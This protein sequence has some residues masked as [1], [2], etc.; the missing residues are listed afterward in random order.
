[1][2]GGGSRNGDKGLVVALPGSWQL[3]GLVTGGVGVPEESSPGGAVLTGWVSL[4]VFEQKC[5]PGSE[6]VSVH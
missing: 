3:W 6:A 2:A 1:M 4:H 5:E